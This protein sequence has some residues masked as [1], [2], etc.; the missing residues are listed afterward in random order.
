MGRHARNIYRT[1]ELSEE[2]SKNYE[3]VKK[4][5]DAYFV[6]TRNL[7]YESACFHRRH[8]ATGESVDQYVTALHTLA[9]RC[10]YGV[11]KERMSLDR[12]VVRLRDSNLSKA[13][14]M[15]ATL[16]LKTALSRARTKEAVQQQHDLRSSAYHQATSLEVDAVHREACG[17]VEQQ[18]VNKD[19]RKCAACDRA[20]HSKSSCPAKRAICYGFQRRG[21]FAAVFPQKQDFTNAEASA[22]ELVET[23]KPPLLAR[24]SSVDRSPAA[25]VGCSP[26]ISNTFVACTG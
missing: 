14:Q 16:N 15:D 21:H 3:S 22:F 9:D 20:R 26:T 24:Y 1:F 4:R 18:R 10:D 23:F 17:W 5:F 13:L 19:V 2:Q 6:P 25:C 12:V 8:Q 7:V 11:M